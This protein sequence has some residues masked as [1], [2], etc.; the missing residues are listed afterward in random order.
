MY[1]ELKV[2]HIEVLI[3]AG[4]LSQHSPKVSLVDMK[5][6]ESG[7]SYLNRQVKSTSIGSDDLFLKFNVK[8]KAKLSKP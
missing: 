2:S 8:Q 4:A 6:L 7:Q 5:Y 1:E 3:V